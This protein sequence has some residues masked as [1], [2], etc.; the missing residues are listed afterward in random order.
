[1]MNRIL[2]TFG[3]TILCSIVLAAGDDVIFLTGFESCDPKATCC[4]NQILFTE[5][6]PEGNHDTWGGEWLLPGFEV[7]SEEIV[8]GQARF[9]PISSNYSLARIVH[10]LQVQDVEVNFTL[11][12]E[13]AETQGIGFYVRSNGGYLNQTFPTGEG[14]A[15]FVE[16]FVN[17]TAGLGLWYERDGAEISFIRDYSQNY[18]LNDETPYRVKFQVYQLSDTTT[19]LRAKLWPVGGVEPEAWHV[20]HVDDYLPLQNTAGHFFLDSW[21]TQQSGE[22]IPATR[23]DDIEIKQLCNPLLGISSLQTL[24]SGFEFAEGP[25][26][27]DDHYLF[28]DIT[29]NT[30]YRWDSTLGLQVHNANSG[31]SNGLNL[32]LD[33]SLLAAEN[34]LRRVSI[35]DGSGTTTLLDSYQG[36]QFNSPNDLVMSDLGILYFTD[37]DYGLNGRPRELPYN[38]LFR[39]HPDTGLILEYV[40]DQFASK[41]NGIRLSPDQQ[42]L[43]WNDSQAG[44]L[45]Q[46]T[47]NPDG[48]LSNLTQIAENLIIPDGMCVDQNGN[49]YVATWNAAL[50]VFSPAGYHWG[51]IPTFE[52]STTNCTFGG[53]DLNTLFITTHTAIHSITMN[54]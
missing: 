49:I 41:P 22:I 52:T 3:M 45:N 10:P 5:S 1:M 26:W 21:S 54:P 15:V 6:F 44:R 48:S 9:R 11:Y 14:Y 35:D 13:N 24:E 38:G 29:A 12:F 2:L 47:I 17:N 33:G 39:F 28:S 23:V 40:G 20:E 42:T 51:S 36:N 53:A 7:E 50:E 16:K 37:P 30:I 46:M 8:N 18:E 34:T 32:T 31:N 19:Q 25:V 4:A 27:R 43:Y